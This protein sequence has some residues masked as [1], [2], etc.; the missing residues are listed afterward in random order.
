VWTGNADGE[1]RPGLTGISAAAPILFDLVN[2]MES[3]KWFDTPHEDLTLISVCSRSGYRA[4]PD[5]PESV[6]IQ[7]CI[8]GL[9]SEACPF[10]KIIHLNK[11]KTVQVTSECLSQNEIVN[12]PWFVLPPAMEYYYRKKHPEYKVL[13][14]VYPGC[15]VSNNISVMEFIYPTSGIKIFIPRDQ[16]GRQTRIIPELAHRNPSKKIF[17]H[18]DEAYIGTTRYI[19]ETEIIAGAGKH[20]L[21][22]VDE[23]GNSIRCSFTII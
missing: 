10:H 7:A 12:A 15:Q 16:T 20:L 5:C 21:T 13:P 19:H 6:E 2:L 1:G 3:G 11:S 17:W 14:P 23:D 8:N 22:A 18:L 9:R 4:G